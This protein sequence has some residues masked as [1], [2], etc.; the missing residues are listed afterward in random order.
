MLT[1]SKTSEMLFIFGVVGISLTLQDSVIVEPRMITII[2][3][4][5]REGDVLLLNTLGL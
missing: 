5:V 4:I 3:S 2:F 1:A